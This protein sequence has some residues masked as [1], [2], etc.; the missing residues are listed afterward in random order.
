MKTLMQLSK[1]PTQTRIHIRTRIQAW[2]MAILKEYIGRPHT[3]KQYFLIQYVYG[4]SIQKRPKLMETCQSKII[5]I[6][7]TQLFLQS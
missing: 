1:A 4:S 7:E 6:M 5:I 3:T 2:H